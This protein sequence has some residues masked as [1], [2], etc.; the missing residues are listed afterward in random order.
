MKNKTVDLVLISLFAVIIAL[1]AWIQI[2]ATV[3]FTLQIFGVFSALL[4]LGG[5]RG[6]AATALYLLL[7]A[8]GLPIFHGFTGGIGIILGPTGGYLIG[9]LAIGAAYWLIT[10]KA[11][12][13]LKAKI[14]ALLTG[15]LLCYALGT[16]W[17]SASAKISL[18]SAVIIGVLPFVLPDLIKL[19]LAVLLADKLKSKLKFI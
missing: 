8:I 12:E 9:F 16:L 13:G 11:G 1:C 14:L 4:L 6:T 10:K 3:A 18:S 15:L 7:G 5:K 2:P 17:L 19:S